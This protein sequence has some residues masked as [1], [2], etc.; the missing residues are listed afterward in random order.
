MAA[1]VLASTVALVAKERESVDFSHG[2]PCCYLLLILFPAI[3]DIHIA[4][5]LCLYL[6]GIFLCWKMLQKQCRNLWHWELPLVWKKRVS[7]RDLGPWV[8]G[9]CLSELGTSIRV[10]IRLLTRKG[11]F[12]EWVQG[13]FQPRN[14]VLFFCFSNFVY[15]WLAEARGGGQSTGARCSFLTPPLLLPQFPVKEQ[16][17]L[18]HAQPNV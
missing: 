7:A 8:R 12:P 15:I 9:R 14:S 2:E 1:G 11:M 6:P 10:G 17:H 3:T 4:A 13:Y 5:A 16:L 18:S